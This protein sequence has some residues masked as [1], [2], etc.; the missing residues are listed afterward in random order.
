VDGTAFNAIVSPDTY[1]PSGHPVV[2]LGAAETV[3]SPLAVVTVRGRQ[4]RK[5]AYW[6]ALAAGMVNVNKAA[7]AL[8]C[9]LQLL[10]R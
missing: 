7:V 2:L 10:H 4:K 6:N 8:V 1:L 9:P 5:D 3:P